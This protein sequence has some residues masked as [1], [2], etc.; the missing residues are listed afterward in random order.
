MIHSGIRGSSRCVSSIYA[1]QLAETW[2]S[3]YGR[4]YAQ[5]VPVSGDTAKTHRN[6]LDLGKVIA[7]HSERIKER[8]APREIDLA[9][10]AWWSELNRQNVPVRGLLDEYRRELKTSIEG[11]QRKPW[12]KSAAEKWIRWTRHNDFPN[13]GKPDEKI[14]FAVRQ[15]CAEARSNDF[16]IG[17]RDAGLVAGVSYCTAARVINKLCK[18]GHL[19]KNGERR[20]LRHAQ[21]Y[22]LTA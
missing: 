7:L 9:F 16:F 10:Q 6:L 18:F 2:L 17:A 13:S 14:L 20:Q 3:W 19:E 8:L 4:N 21:A 15:H 5:L 12:F 1:G 22:R 11:A